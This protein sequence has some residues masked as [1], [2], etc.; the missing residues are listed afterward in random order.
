MPRLGK[1][2]HFNPFRNNHHFVEAT[3]LDD[4]QNLSVRDPHRGS[5]FSVH[6][7]MKNLPGSRVLRVQQP[8]SALS[9]RLR[10]PNVT[11]EV[12]DGVS[13]AR[14]R[15]PRNTNPEDIQ[16]DLNEI[17]RVLTLRVHDWEQNLELDSSL[18]LKLLKASFDESTDELCLKTYTTLPTGADEP[19]VPQ[20]E[21]VDAGYMS[22]EE[23]PPAE[24]IDD[25]SRDIESTPISIEDVGPEEEI[26]RI[27]ISSTDSC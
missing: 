15:L 23:R 10:S 12:Q 1:R 11:H 18:D 21:S 8:I 25:S 22:E 27:S 24:S 16:L 26:D 2:Y 3:R 17:S 19:Q 5:I 13:I 20:D 14:I 4:V 7:L 9:G 6:S